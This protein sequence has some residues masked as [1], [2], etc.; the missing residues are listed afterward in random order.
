M[1]EP[2]IREHPPSPRQC[3]LDSSTEVNSALQHLTN[4]MGFGSIRTRSGY[5]TSEGV[6][7]NQSRCKVI[8]KAM[9]ELTR[10]LCLLL[11][12]TLPGPPKTLRLYWLLFLRMLIYGCEGL[13]LYSLTL[14]VM[15][16]ED[17]KDPGVLVELTRLL[18]CHATERAEGRRDRRSA[19]DDSWINLLSDVNQTY[20][21]LSGVLDELVWPAPTTRNRSEVVTS[22]TPSMDTLAIFPS[23]TLDTLSTTLSISPSSTLEILSSTLGISP[24]S[25]MDILSTSPN[26]SLTIPDSRNAM[27]GYRLG[28]CLEIFEIETSVSTLTCSSSL[29]APLCVLMVIFLCSAALGYLCASIGKKGAGRQAGEGI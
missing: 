28:W 17:A 10:D 18:L 4:K 12:Y 14:T 5:D 25:T 22:T 3:Q 16:G 23:S 6:V 24:S 21:E 20:P 9:V 19:D 26:L 11:F 27:K 2:H 15:V 29:M 7:H 1:A 8:L 13:I